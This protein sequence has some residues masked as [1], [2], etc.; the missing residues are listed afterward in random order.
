MRRRNGKSPGTMQPIRS[1][2]YPDWVCADCGMKH[3]RHNP[4][5]ATW[6]L[7]RCDICGKEKAV[8]EPRDFGHLSLTEILT[9]GERHK[10]KRLG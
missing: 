4:G 10:D 8:T 9:K 7:G 1:S 6:H 5:I 2:S 3:G